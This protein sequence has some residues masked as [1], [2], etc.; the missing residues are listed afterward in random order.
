MRD[1][2]S[3]TAARR[4]EARA[5]IGLLLGALVVLTSCA[6]TE[7]RR[8]L[9]SGAIGC[10]VPEV[11]ISEE[12]GYSW[13]ARCRGHVFYCG[14]GAEGGACNEETPRPEG[15][16]L[17]EAPEDDSNRSK[18]RRGVSSGYL[19]CPA[20]EVALSDEDGGSWTAAC[21]GRTVLCGAAGGVH[22]KKPLEAR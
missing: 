21:R 5:W 4:G 9:T 19:G 14:A 12:T 22:C 3:V 11:A 10:P 16:R 13:V 2:D 15:A 8:R 6:M 17:V 1:G 20:M 18:V 7:T